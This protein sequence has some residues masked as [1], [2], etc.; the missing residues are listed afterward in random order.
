M[1]QLTQ[2]VL[3]LGTKARR[4]GWHTPG[5]AALYALLILATVL[6][7]NLA[8]Q[9]PIDSSPQGA[10]IQTAARARV[11]ALPAAQ[12]PAGS[13][14]VSST[15]PVVIFEDDQLL[16]SAQNA[17]VADVLFALRAATGADI[18]IPVS[19]HS[20]RVT[21]QL[22]PGPARKVLADL[23]GWSSF[24]YIIEG[25]DD[26]PLSVHSVTLMARGKGPGTTLP[27]TA[28][29]AA[30]GRGAAPAPGPAQTDAASIRENVPEPPT[31]AA[32]VNSDPSSGSPSDSAANSLPSTQQRA[33]L[34]PGTASGASAS[35]GGSKSPSDMIQE[36][37]QM[38]QQRRTM[39]EQLNQTVGGQRT[40]PSP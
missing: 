24:D 20:E 6:P 16:I 32:D 25:A 35:A 40:S 8:A 36:L 17:T 12:V 5:R 14:Q 13:S 11:P 39:Q 2:A 22:G 26:D 28:A 29:N 10:P 34:P 23:L 33:V 31:T 19:A 4:L 9:Q 1:G 21:A 7:L 30:G 3:G 37:Q 38:Y 15:Q 27:I 18:D